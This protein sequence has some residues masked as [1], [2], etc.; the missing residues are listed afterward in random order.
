[1]S[2]VADLNACGGLKT[3]GCEDQ[4]THPDLHLLDRGSLQRKYTEFK[5]T[6]IH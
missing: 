2:S 6:T 5:L 1:M 3:T 4:E